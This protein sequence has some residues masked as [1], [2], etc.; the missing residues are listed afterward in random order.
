MLE[1]RICYLKEKRQ[2]E[3]DKPEL[4]LHSWMRQAW[5]APSF[6]LQSPLAHDNPFRAWWLA[7]ASRSSLGVLMMS[8]MII[9]QIGRAIP[10]IICVRKIGFCLLVN[11]LACFCRN[12]LDKKNRTT[13][14]WSDSGGWLIGREI[15]S[16]STFL[17]A[18]RSISDGCSRLWN[19]T[20][21]PDS[22]GV[23][24]LPYMM[25]APPRTH[26]FHS[27]SPMF[28]QSKNMS[29]S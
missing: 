7:V 19:E 15:K 22:S 14:G 9:I 25:C 20:D 4:R 11:L 24:F 16:M 17:D 6:V 5:L 28:C 27:P 3:W 18:A 10:L 12:G 26:Q 8:Y 21:T 13:P 1:G 23:T 2:S 29:N